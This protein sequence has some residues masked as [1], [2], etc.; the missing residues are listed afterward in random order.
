MIKKIRKVRVSK[1]VFVAVLTDLS[2]VFDRISHELLLAK[3]HALDFDKI[4][5]TFMH[6]YLSQWLQKTKV[7]STLTK[8]MG[9]LFGVPQGSVLGP[10]LFIVYICDLFILNDHLEFGNCADSF[11]L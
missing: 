1:G 9:I 7:G 2:K 6:A 8:L 10:L 11:C 5:L 4:S 3:L